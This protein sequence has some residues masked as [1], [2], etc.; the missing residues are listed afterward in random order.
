MKKSISILVLLVVACLRPSGGSC[1][2]PSGKGNADVQKAYELRMNG[3]VDE[4]RSLL[5]KVLQADSTLAMA[6]FEMARLKNYLLTAAENVTTEEILASASKAVQYEP[7]NVCYAY[8]KALA[9]FWNA[10]MSMQKD[11]ANVKP[12]ILETAAAFEAVLTLKPDYYEAMLYLV[13]IYGML[14]GDMG[15][16]SLKAVKYA[17]KLSAADKYFGAKAKSDLLPDGADL[18]KYW[19][20]I[21]TKEKLNSNIIMELGKAYLAAGDPD[22]AKKFFDQA[23]KPDP[24]KNSLI[25]DMARYHLMKVMQNKDLVKTE[26]PLAKPFIDQYLMIKP[27]P[28]VPMRAYAIGLQAKIEMG[29][30]NKDEAEKLMKQAQ[31]LDP[32]FS[33]ASGTPTQVLFDPPGTISHHYFSF[34]SFF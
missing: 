25:L 15:G 27:K 19:Q 1:S 28:T 20:E 22:N 14:P 26:L 4:A 23:I 8:Y 18:V 3:K 21:L 6:H 34:F 7:K 9:C 2:S 24:S 17:E 31:K 29:L 10:F 12:R 32:H 30:G 16:D 13:D 11:Q 33:K 5:E